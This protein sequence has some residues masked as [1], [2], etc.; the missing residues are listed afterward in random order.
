MRL[1]PSLTGPTSAEAQLAEAAAH[2]H[3]VPPSR[4]C[5]H[6]RLSDQPLAGE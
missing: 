6:H 1:Q 4:A 2:E 5:H 3:V